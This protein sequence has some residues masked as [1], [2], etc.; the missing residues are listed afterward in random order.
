MVAR[1]LS[2]AFL[3]IVATM[4]TAS[5]T[6]TYVLDVVTESGIR[7]EATLEMPNSGDL[8]VTVTSDNQHSKNGIVTFSTPAKLTLAGT[9]GVVVLSKTDLESPDVV[10]KYAQNESTTQSSGSEIKLQVFR[11]G[12]ISFV[13]DRIE[14]QSE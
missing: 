7:G 11:S 1:F 4:I 3:L 2:T 10:V 12:G 6:Q 9:Y 14:S 5:E 13:S 8:E